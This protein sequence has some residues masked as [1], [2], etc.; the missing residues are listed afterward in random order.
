MKKFNIIAVHGYDIFYYD[1]LEEMWI[2][3]SEEPDKF[4]FVVPEESLMIHLQKATE[5]WRCP[6]TK[7]EN[8][9]IVSL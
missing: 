8:I 9:F 4:K 5:L 2:L 1:G 6:D 3:G 7:V